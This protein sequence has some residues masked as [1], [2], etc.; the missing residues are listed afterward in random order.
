MAERQE[1]GVNER[2]GDYSIAVYREI[3][4]GIKVGNKS[5]NYRGVQ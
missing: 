1:V 2:Y 4:M 3:R 5:V